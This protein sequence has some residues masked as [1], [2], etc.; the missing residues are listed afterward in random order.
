MVHLWYH[1][2]K[3]KKEASLT[4]RWQW[5][6]WL[7][8]WSLLT[9]WGWGLPYCLMDAKVLVLHSAFFDTTVVGWGPS[10]AGWQRVGQGGLLVIV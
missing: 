2:S 1:P 9:M 10:G 4:T 5:I 7:P 6:S 8:T 3:Q